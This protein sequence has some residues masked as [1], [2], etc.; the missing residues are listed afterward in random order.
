[1][2]FMFYGIIH[3]FSFSIIFFLATCKIFHTIWYSWGEEM[4]CNI[5]GI[6]YTGIIRLHIL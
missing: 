3:M 2:V 6:G 4:H 1:M 5:L